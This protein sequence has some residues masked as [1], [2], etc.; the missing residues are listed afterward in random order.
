MSPSPP[1]LNC[2]DRLIAAGTDAFRQNGFDATSVDEICSAAGVSKG[3]FFHHFESKASLAHACLLAWNGM[4]MKLADKVAQLNIADPVQHLFALLDLFVGVLTD[5]ARQPASCLAGTL[6][7]EVAQSNPLLRDAAHTCF[8]GMAQM[9]TRHIEAAAK[10]RGVTLD[11]HSLAQLWNAAIQGGLILFKASQDPEDLRS[12][13]T[14]IRRYIGV[15][16]KEP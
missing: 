2:R 1:Q 3:A 5:P 16:L 11:A 4:S 15:L 10:A 8:V 14:H 9:L 7:Q 13:L 6:V 12:G